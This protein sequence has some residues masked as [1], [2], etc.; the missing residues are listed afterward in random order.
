MTHTTGLN[1][2]LIDFFRAEMAARRITQPELATLS[3]IPVVSLQR[4]LAGKR[5]MTVEV[6]E[7]IAGAF[8]LSAVQAAMRAESAR[9]EREARQDDQPNTRGA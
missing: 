5:M 2:A 1:G 9:E 8:D 4:Y 6:V 3:G 7:Q